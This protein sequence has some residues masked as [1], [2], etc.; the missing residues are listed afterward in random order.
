GA[1]QYDPTLG[2]FNGY[3]YSNNNPTT[4]S[5]PTGLKYLLGDCACYNSGNSSGKSKPAAGKSSGKS[6]GRGNSAPDYPDFVPD[7]TCAWQVDGQKQEGR[8]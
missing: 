1:R 6:N 4:Y 3:T 8:A 7:E 5:D 2:R